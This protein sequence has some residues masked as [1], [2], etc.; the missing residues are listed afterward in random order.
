M[1]RGLLAIV[2]HWW[3]NRNQQWQQPLENG[4]TGRKKEVPLD[5]NRKTKGKAEIAATD[6]SGNERRNEDLCNETN[7]QKKKMG[8]SNNKAENQK[9][10]RAKGMGKEQKWGPEKAKDS[11][12]SYWKVQASHCSGA[13]S[14]RCVLYVPAGHGTGAP[15]P[16]GQYAAAGQRSPVS[17]SSGAA[18]V[19]PPTQ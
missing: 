17:P 3:H 13:E 18:V 2:T 12:S 10:Q 6:T 14:P 16:T 11:K 4:G 1:G 5:E 7:R 19:A 9:N 8:R 15:L